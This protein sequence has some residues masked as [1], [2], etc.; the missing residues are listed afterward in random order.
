M[1]LRVPVRAAAMGL[2]T[3]GAA[4]IFACPRPLAPV[5]T[6]KVT[7]TAYTHAASETAS[8]SVGVAAWGD[9][10]EPGMKVLAVSRD[11]LEDGLYYG[12]EVEIDG[13]DGKWSVRDKMNRR[14]ERKI[15]LYLGADV[16][17]ARAF[18]KR[19]VT[20]RWHEKPDPE[21]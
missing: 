4:L 14:W 2:L 13:V 12:A 21:R 6:R 10:L 19:Q 1:P 20:I 11:L 5:K 3:L 15:D 18:G 16:E 7:A 9:S 17:A 8:D